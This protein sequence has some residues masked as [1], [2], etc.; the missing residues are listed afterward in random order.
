MLL[1]FRYFLAEFPSLGSTLNW[2]SDR[3]KLLSTESMEWI[4]GTPVYKLCQ[5]TSIIFRLMAAVWW[6]CFIY[7]VLFN[8]NFL[9]KSTKEKFWNGNVNNTKSESSCLVAMRYPDFVNMKIQWR[10]I[11]KWIYDYLSFW[12]LL[13]AISEF[14]MW[15][16]LKCFQ[17]TI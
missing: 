15:R 17:K 4:N 1:W 13:R 5:K 12:C 3:S 6:P 14:V 10:N 7:F 2:T 9:T 8:F 11:F 16:T